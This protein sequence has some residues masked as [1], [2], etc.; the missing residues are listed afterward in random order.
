LS[1]AIV[2]ERLA[3]SVNN[4]ASLPLH[5]GSFRIIGGPGFHEYLSALLLP[6]KLTPF[7]T[8]WYDNDYCHSS[9]NGLCLIPDGPPWR[10]KASASASRL[11]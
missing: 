4:C 11:L 5:Q 1:E 9:D 7:L 6:K 10:R 2:K 8:G 3:R